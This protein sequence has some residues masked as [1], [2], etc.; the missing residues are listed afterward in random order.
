MRIK[1][2]CVIL[3]FSLSG[4]SLTSERVDDYKPSGIPNFQ[5]F[6]NLSCRIEASSHKADVGQTVSLLALTS[7]KPKV[8]F[9]SSGVTSPM[10]KLFE[11]DD[12]LVIQVVASASGSTDTVVLNKKNGTF[13]RSSAGNFAGVYATAGIG[14][15]K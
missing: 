11:S 2:I 1:I 7:E 6:E 15:C 3:L 10:Q 14:S 12:T 8:L 13:A 5:M 9:S 4:C